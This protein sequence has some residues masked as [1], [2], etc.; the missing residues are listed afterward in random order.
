MVYAHVAR[1]GGSISAE[2]GVGRLKRPY[3]A[4]SRS[5]PELALMQTLKSALDPAGI[6]NRGR[7]LAPLPRAAE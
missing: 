3:L 7:I 4:L 6:L 2:H 5:A 1:F